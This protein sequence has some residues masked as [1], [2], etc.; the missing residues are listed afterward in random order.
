MR[1]EFASVKFIVYLQFSLISSQDIE[2]ISRMLRYGIDVLYPK[3]TW[4]DKIHILDVS[5]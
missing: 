4:M 1:K 5:H 2:F 3:L